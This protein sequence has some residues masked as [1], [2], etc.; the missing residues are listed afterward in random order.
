M[1]QMNRVQISSGR[2]R[3]S[4]FAERQRVVAETESVQSPILSLES[5]HDVHCGD[6]LPT[7]VLNV[8]NSVADHVLEE[9]LE[10]AT[11]LLIDETG[12]RLHSTMAS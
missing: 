12:D 3:P 2:L 4:V 1:H 6:R 10:D 9:D 7:S 5:I 11:S 8:D